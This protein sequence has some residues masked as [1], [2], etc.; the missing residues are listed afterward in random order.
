[1]IDRSKPLFQAVIQAP[2]PFVGGR[3]MRL[4]LLPLLGEPL[5]FPLPGDL[6]VMIEAT[7]ET[8]L[9]LGG[10]SAEIPLEHATYIAKKQFDWIHLLRAFWRDLT[11]T[12]S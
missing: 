3:S 4:D 1:M 12:S 8:G 10:V 11:K 6:F 9:E 2:N 5:L 7:K